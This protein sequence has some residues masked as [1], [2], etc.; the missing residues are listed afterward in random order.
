MTKRSQ[1]LD[2]SFISD[3]LITRFPR[4]NRADADIMSTQ[5]ERVIGEHI[6]NQDDLAF[7]TRL[8]NGK[9][10]LTVLTIEPIRRKEG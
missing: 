1:S 6:A 7:V 3:A 4:M 10:R 8:P 5:L 2:K 9:S